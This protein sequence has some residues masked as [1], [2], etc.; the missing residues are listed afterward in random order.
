MALRRCLSLNL[1][2]V[3]APSSMMVREIPTTCGKLLV[4]VSAGRSSLTHKACT[5]FG[6]ITK[7]STRMQMYTY[8]YNGHGYHKDS[9]RHKWIEKDIEMQMGVDV[10][11]NIIDYMQLQWM[12][13]R[14]NVCINECM[15]LYHSN[16]FCVVMS[17]CCVL[18]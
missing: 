17:C 4:S 16:L 11:I 3:G 10:D 18:P 2:V 15:L 13:D 5:K 6:K 12:H 1:G 7:T 14:R 9:Y 8:V